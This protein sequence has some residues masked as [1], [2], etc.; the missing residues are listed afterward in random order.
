MW[1]GAMEMH[2]V[3]SRMFAIIVVFDGD[4][5]AAMLIM[6]RIVSVVVG[7]V[8]VTIVVSSGVVSSVVVVT[9]TTVVGR[10][11]VRL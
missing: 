3:A 8:V 10:V 6:L 9:T 7:P 11:W 5:N 4:V 1:A 2:G